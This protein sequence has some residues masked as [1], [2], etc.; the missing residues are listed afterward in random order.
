M[1]FST[2]FD[3]DSSQLT[4]EAEVETRLLLKLFIDLG[5]QTD[6]IVPKEHVPALII[7]DGRKTMPKTVDFILKDKNNIARIIVEAKNPLENILDAW[8]QTASYALSHNSDKSEDNRV[9]WLLL[10]NGHFTGL[11]PH[12]SKTPVVILQLSDFASGMPPYVTLRMYIKFDSI[13]PTP[14][15]ALPFEPLPPHKLNQL[16]VDS[17]NLVWKKEKLAPADAFFEFCK[18]IFI[19]LQEDKRREKLLKDTETYIIPLTEDWLRAQKATSNHPVRDVLFKNLHMKLEDAIIN[20]KKKRIFEKDETL[21][22][23]A[24]TCAELIKMFQ[25]VNLSSI[26][27]D[28]NGRMFE[29]F[30][31]ASI[32]GKDLGQYFTPRSVVDFMTRIALRNVDVTN[33][34]KVIDACCGTAG[35]LIEVMAYLTGR[36]RDD[37]R[38]TEKEREKARNLICN[39]RLF[40]V[41]ANERVSRIARINMY[42]HGDGGSHI[43]HGDGLDADSQVNPDMTSEQKAEVVEY[44]EKVV[45]GFFDIILTNPPFSMTYISNN[46]DEKRIMQQHELTVDKPSVKSSILFLNRYYELLSPN[47]EMLIVLDDTVLNGKSF[48]GV[49][50]WVLDKFV[51]LG[52]HSLPFNAFFKAKANIKTSILHLRKKIDASEKQGCVFMSISNNIGHDN[53]LKDTP[54]RNNLTEILMAYLD[55]QRTGNLLT[56]IQDNADPNENL[57]CPLQYWLVSA[58]KFSAE[59]FDSFFYCPDLYDT[60]AD[61][62]KAA[63]QKKILLIDGNNL[64]LRKKLSGTE[65]KSMKDDGKLYRYIEI[66]DVTQYGLITKYIEGMFGDLPSRGEYLVHTGDILLALNNSSRGTVVLV[67]REFDNAICTSGFLVIVPKNED[68]SMLLWYVLRSEICRKQIYYLAQTASQPELKIEAWN[69]YFKIPI[70]TGV[71]RKEAIAKAKEFNRHIAALLDANKYRFDFA[72]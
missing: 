70:P 14:K 43:F 37:T 35:F 55:W 25:S 10:S 41:E 28:L 15:S 48:E 21:K 72:L 24:S 39:E 1:A 58:D 59:R 71:E 30:L 52:V 69:Q 4:T 65:K 22:L 17:H 49:R 57:E 29:V 9:K 38:F 61:I 11:F 63:E 31:A 60:Y 19:K 66:G 42:L 12:D 3:I 16:F 8:G 40:G 50:L 26:D 32:R 56:T 54:F 62:Q 6:Y 51:V 53:S 68:D 36:L 18:F 47:K 34:P 20:D 46:P 44:K 13:T 45:D 23:S 5:Y 64:N 27:E 2:L 67:S 33:P 7:H